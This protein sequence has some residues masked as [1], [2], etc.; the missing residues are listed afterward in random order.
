MVATDEKLFDLPVFED[1]L[2][3]ELERLHTERAGGRRPASRRRWYLM[4][5]AGLSAAAC[6]AVGAVVVTQDDLDDDTTDIANGPPADDAIVVMESELATRWYDEATGEWRVRSRGLADPGQ[7]AVDEAEAPVDVE[8]TLRIVEQPDGS[9]VGHI[10]MVDHVRR[11]YY[12]LDDVARAV[13]LAAWRID[14][15][16][17]AELEAGG[18]TADGQELVDGRQLDRYVPPGG[19]PGHEVL[20]D[21][22]TGHAVETTDAEITTTFTYLPRTPENLALVDGEVPEGY[23]KVVDGEVVSYLGRYALPLWP[24]SFWELGRPFDPLVPP[25]LPEE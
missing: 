1:R 7:Y 9:R 4:T 5:V 13:Q 15:A 21:P 6:L 11:E 2:W 3:G 12:E 25:A 17:K 19:L 22:G 10:T 8:E 20:V 23:R 14:A 16:L 18:L 24:P